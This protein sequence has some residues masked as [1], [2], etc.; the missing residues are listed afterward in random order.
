MQE[1][2]VVLTGAAGG[3][4]SYLASYFAQAHAQLAL[5]DVNKE[6]LEELK[7][8]LLKYS[9]PL[10]I[11]V[12]DQRNKKEVFDTAQKILEDFG[13]IDI[14]INNA[15]IG[16]HA[17]LAETNLQ[18]WEN[19]L[20]VNFWGPLYFIYAFL[21]QMQK[22]GG[23]IVNITS[24]QVFF[25]IPT[26]GAYTVTKTALATFSD[27]L[28]SELRKDKILV[29]T[30]Y[31][32]MVNTGFYR[33]IE[34]DTL[35][36][37]L[38]LKLLPL[39]SQKPE[40]VAQIIFEAIQERKEVEMV[41][42]LNTVGKYLRLNPFLSQLFDL[43]AFYALAGLP[44]ADNLPF[45]QRLTE[46]SLLFTEKLPPI[47]FEI[48]EIMIGEHE[49][50]DQEGKL[51]IEFRVRWGATN[52]FHYANPFH[53]DFLKSKL[54]GFVSVGGLCENVPCEGFLKLNYFSDQTIRYDFSF[55]ASG[56]RWDF[57]GTKKQIYPWNLP[58]SHTTLFGELRRRSDG[59]LISR[60]VMH[61]PPES[62]ME[63]LRSLR[64]A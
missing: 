35:G 19:L 17:S 4:G 5:I 42:P 57:L 60:S 23:H 6:R 3:I 1:K 48:E 30:V 8:R 40:K 2:V 45:W 44:S 12:V 55:T 13:K 27:I 32:Y 58:W 56:E 37:E 18:D 14:L 43:V 7:T 63:F 46:L 21:P 38:M 49:F 41:H 9:A 36:S 20:A 51:P 64:F 31:P 22:N 54:Q 24:G 53:P 11:Y 52:L 62:A 15:G 50:V 29:T 61:F 59:K 26:W 28:R 16:F 34:A 33:N 25:R 39:Y 47:G 10:R